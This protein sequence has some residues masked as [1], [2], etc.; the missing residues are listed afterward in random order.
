MDEEKRMYQRN[1]VIMERYGCGITRYRYKN[2]HVRTTHTY[3]DPAE[4]GWEP[5]PS[6]HG[7]PGTQ[8]AK[9]LMG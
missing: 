6:A 1:D 4:S 3:M 9:E 2:G 5:S 7:E 8:V